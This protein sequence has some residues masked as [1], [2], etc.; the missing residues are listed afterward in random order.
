MPLYYLNI[1]DGSHLIEDP[2]GS[3]HSNLEQARDEAIRSARQILAERVLADEVI[4]GQVFEITD[5]T[6]AVKATVPL[7]SVLKLA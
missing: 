4:D 2:E 1:R 5:E 7:K 3:D 6:G